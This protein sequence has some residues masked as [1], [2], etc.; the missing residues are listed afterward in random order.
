MIF[1]IQWLLLLPPWMIQRQLDMREEE[2]GKTGISGRGGGL[3]IGR[4]RR[5]RER[6]RGE[7]RD[8]LRGR[9]VLMIAESPGSFYLV[10]KNSVP[11]DSSS[12]RTSYVLKSLQAIQLIPQITNGKDPRGVGTGE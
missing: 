9:E 8:Y 6:R 4:R 5:R 10:N 12:S 3:V 11:K 7:V 2:E 1:P